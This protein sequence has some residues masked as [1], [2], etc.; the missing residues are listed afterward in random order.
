MSQPGAEKAERMVLPREIGEILERARKAV[1]KA[2]QEA[3]VAMGALEE[4]EEHYEAVRAV[5]A[6]RQ[7]KLVEEAALALEG[8]IGPCDLTRD[9]RMLANE[10]EEI[11]QRA[12]IGE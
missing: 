5:A 8:A 11:G 2:E 9:L 7:V 12:G 3:A 6:G 1:E 4:A 10:L